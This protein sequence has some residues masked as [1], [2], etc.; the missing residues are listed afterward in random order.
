MDTKHHDVGGYTHNCIQCH[1]N[2]TNNA[3]MGKNTLAIFAAFQSPMMQTQPGQR[4]PQRP[5][6]VLLPQVQ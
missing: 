3:P 2:G 6:Q 5:L 1:A 4:P